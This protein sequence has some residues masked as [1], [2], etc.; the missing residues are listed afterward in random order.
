MI[1][2]LV[3]SQLQEGGPLTSTG[4]A[5]P[6]QRFPHKFLVFGITF[7]LIGSV[8]LLRTAGVMPDTWALWT[9]IPLIV[10]LMLLYLAFAKDGP[11]GYVFVGMILTLVGLVFLLLNTVMSSVELAR[12]WPLFM[13]IAG[14]SLAVYA[15]SKVEPARLTLQIPAAAM[16]L[17]SAV[18]LM[19]S[20]NVIQHDFRRVVGAWWPVTLVA[21][22]AFL[23]WLY[24]ARRGGRS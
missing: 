15:R 14:A 18:F 4:R 19:F 20:L 8:L 12:I 24:Y 9:V 5:T 2:N 13:T 17:L 7:V 16:V 3:D 6:S 1:Y 22:G 11:E 10:G 23:L 21:F